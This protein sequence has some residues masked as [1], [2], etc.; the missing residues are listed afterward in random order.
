MA[1]HAGLDLDARGMCS[2][3]WVMQVIERARRCRETLV[4]LFETKRADS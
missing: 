3:L 4:M 1:Q 2:W